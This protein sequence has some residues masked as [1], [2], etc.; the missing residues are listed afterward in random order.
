MPKSLQ[1]FFQERRQPGTEPVRSHTADSRGCVHFGKTPR[2]AIGQ[3][4]GADK[5]YGINAGRR[6]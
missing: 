5:S 2:D 3:A 4:V 6:Q 1:D